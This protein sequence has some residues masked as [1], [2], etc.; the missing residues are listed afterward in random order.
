MSSSSKLRKSCD[1]CALTKVGCT[2]EKPACARCAKRKQPCLYSAAKRVG[3]TSAAHGSQGSKAEGAAL[4]PTTPISISP[5]LAPARVQDV[6]RVLANTTPSPSTPSATAV[7]PPSSPNL[8]PPQS[9]S[10]YPNIFQTLISSTGDT[11]VPSMPSDSFPEWDELFAKS[12]PLSFGDP[13]DDDTSATSLFDFSGLEDFIDQSSSTDRS[14]SSSNSSN[15]T[16][17]SSRSSGSSLFPGSGQLTANVAPTPRSPVAANSPSQSLVVAHPHQLGEVHTPATSITPSQT[18][19]QAFQ[20]EVS[21]CQCLARV[22]GLLARVC[23]SASVPWNKPDNSE[24]NRSSTEQLPDFQHIVAQNEQTGEVIRNVLQCSC[25]ND[26]YLLVMLS[27]VVFKIIAWY[28]AAAR[29]ASGE[30]PVAGRGASGTS[31]SSSAECWKSS[32]HHY[33]HH[34]HHHQHQHQ[35]SPFEPQR[36]SL[37]TPSSPSSS[38]SSSTN[39]NNQRIFDDDSGGE[40]QQRIA[41]QRVLSKLAGVQVSIDEL[42]DRL[43]KMWDNKPSRNDKG[44]GDNKMM[45]VPSPPLLVNGTSSTSGSD[46][47]CSLAIAE[48]A[49]TRPFSAELA[50]TLEADLRKRLYELSQAIVERL[51]GG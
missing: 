13:L 39:Y 16:N 31:G 10:S 49:F 29:A 34:H 17:I 41:I 18:G 14:N 37:P 20:L 38:S 1:S 42:S 40:D 4:I 48:N 35:N 9:S 19:K 46:A 36:S 47:G 28:S 45:M 8:G 24:G 11:S 27:L 43:S 2:K 22:L 50:H 30:E 21:S 44:G 7:F 51:R 32:H 33:H 5:S 26:S 25:S 15:S 23:P 3:R 6:A 12:P